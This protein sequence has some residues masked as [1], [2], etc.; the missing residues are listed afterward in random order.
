MSPPSEN[1][2]ASVL[3]AVFAQASLLP[4]ECEHRSL[5]QPL[6]KIIC[7]CSVATTRIHAARASA[8]SN[9][10]PTCVCARGGGRIKG[11]LCHPPNGRVKQ[12]ERRDTAFCRNPQVQ[13]CFLK[14]RGLY[15]LR[16]DSTKRFKL[17]TANRHTASS[18]PLLQK[19][20]STANR[21]RAF[22]DSVWTRSEFNK[23][24]GSRRQ[25]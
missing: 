19:N 6:G 22:P 25:A 2:V 11:G 12:R 24:R 15:R 20:A 16:R 3:P 8:R 13:P 1:L 9:G 18:K 4:A 23:E 17:V 7:E 5:L 21:Y 14:S 10:F